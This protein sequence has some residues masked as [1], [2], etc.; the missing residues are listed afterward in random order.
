LAF[1]AFAKSS[2][3]G[4]A[5]LLPGKSIGP[6]ALSTISA[7]LAKRSDRGLFAQ[8]LCVRKVASN[9]FASSKA[10]L[11]VAWMYASFGTESIAFCTVSVAER[12]RSASALRTLSSTGCNL[13]SSALAAAMDAITAL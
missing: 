1:A 8:A 6:M 3:L 7:T 4:E 10:S 13:V 11:L 5:F 2:A 9:C 12:S